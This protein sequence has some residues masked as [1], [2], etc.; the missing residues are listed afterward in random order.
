MLP[1]QTQL[2]LFSATFP[3]RVRAYASKFA[4]SA[5][6]IELKREELSVEGIKQYYMDCKNEE[7]KYDIL[8]SIYS[9][10]TV[11]QS[12]IFCQVRLSY[13][14]CT[15]NIK[16]VLQRRNTADRIAQR[17]TAEGHRVASLHGAKEGAERDR[18]MDSFREGHEKVL[19]TT[20]V[21]ARGIDIQQVNVVV[22]YDLPM[23]SDRSESAVYSRENEIPDI[24]TYIHRIG[25][26]SCYDPE[27]A[28]DRT[29]VLAN[30]DICTSG[31][32]GRFGRKGVSINFVHDKR[33]W[34]QMEKIEKHTG[35]PI[36]RVGTDNIEEME[37]V[38]HTPPVICA[39][40]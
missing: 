25:A 36:T 2:L 7:A 22:N 21:I 29:S 12:I 20:N 13:P 10:L 14:L 34:E 17:M 27:T 40:C 35:K 8:A 1:K 30:F 18:I 39:C 19:I 9:L 31:R 6:K 38:C 33:T 28:R 26:P 23:T 16:F 11:G 15:L 24:E 32:T 3:D 5:N 37:E 4:P